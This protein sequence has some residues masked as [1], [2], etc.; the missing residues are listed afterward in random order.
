MTT[1]SARQALGIVVLSTMLLGLSGLPVA[2]AAERAGQV[3]RVQGTGL[4][5]RVGQPDFQPVNR[6]EAVNLQ[7]VLATD[8]GDSKLWMR[9]ATPDNGDVSLGRASAFG[10]VAFEHQGGAT[11]F[12]SQVPAGI[13]RFIKRLHQTSP[14]SS[15]TVYSPTAFV[16]VVPGQRAADF[17]VSVLDEN[18]TAVTCI[19]GEIQ[20]DNVDPQFSAGRLLRSCQTVVVERNKQPS[21]VM[22]VTQKVMLNLIDR[23]TIPNTLPREAPQC[24][25]AP[26]PRVESAPFSYDTSFDNDVYFIPG[27]PVFPPFIPPYIPPFIPTHPTMP[28]MPTMPTHPTMPTMPTRPT[29]PTQPTM[30]T[31][32]TTPTTPTMPTH[33]TTPTMPTHPTMTTF[34]TFPTFIGTLITTKPTLNTFKTFPTFIGTLITTKPTLGTFKTFPT[35]IGTH[36]TTKPTLSTFKTFP[37]SIATLITTKSTITPSLFTKPSITPT[38]SHTAIKT[39]IGTVATTPKTTLTPTLSHTMFKT[40]TGTGSTGAKPIIPSISTGKHGT[41]AVPSV[42]KPVI[43]TF[44]QEKEHQQF[45]KQQKQFQHQRIEK[46]PQ[47]LQIEKQPQH[48]KIEKQHQELQIEKQHQS[49]P[50][51]NQMQQKQFQESPGHQRFR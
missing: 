25:Q 27:G 18:R 21:P 11:T 40:F 33:P 20:V 31:T 4:I 6:G 49:I 19:W 12:V 34:K 32:P 8:D 48:F 5:Q 29:M 45:D 9:G 7:D 51:E 44:K 37:T 36:I 47:H 14:P 30:P 42:G 16:V 35:F 2:S 28:T 10:V 23:T 3:M 1:Q 26:P 13:V 43:P 50:R 22:W 17:V 39:L 24:R 41:T 15:Y 46:E 38:F